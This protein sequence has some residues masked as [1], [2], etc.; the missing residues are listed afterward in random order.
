VR[1]RYDDA[2]DDELV[3]AAN[4]GDAAAMEHLYRRHREWAHAVALRF[5]GNAA[6]A[7]DVLQD[8]FAYLF[9]KFPGFVLTCRLRTFLYPA[10]RNRSIDILRRRRTVPLP[11]NGRALPARSAGGESEIRNRVSEVVAGLPEG[12]RDV[13]V[14]RFVDGLKL[15]EIAARLGVPSG[16]VKSRLHNALAALRKQVPDATDSG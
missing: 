1:D 5:C 2:T 3:G 12:Q 9:G 13:V 7:Q 11:E 14:L 8:V 10:L 4:G 16:T 6:D 15:G